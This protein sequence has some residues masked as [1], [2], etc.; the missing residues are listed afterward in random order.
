MSKEAIDLLVNGSEH[1]AGANVPASKR[2]KN[3][4]D[5][6]QQGLSKH[7]HG[8]SKP[9]MGSDNREAQG[10]QSG[11][12]GSGVPASEHI[13]SKTPDARV[14]KARAAHERRE[15]GSANPDGDDRRK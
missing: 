9:E 15:N 4:L 6:D 8:H 11:G 3:T 1:D 7:N 5:K 10:S 2:T 14:Q 13:K 12:A